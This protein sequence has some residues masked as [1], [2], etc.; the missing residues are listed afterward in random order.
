MGRQALTQ[1]ASGVRF[2]K[3]ASVGALGALFDMSVSTTLIFLFDMLSEFAKLIGA[4]VAIIVMFIVNERWTFANWGQQGWM[5]STKRF[6][7]SN[8]VRS[9]GVGVQFLLVRFLRTLPVS[10]PVAGLDLWII[11][12]LPIAIASSMM[13]NY[14]A[15]SVLTWR[16][17][18]E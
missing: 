8:L 11:I 5:A 15:E 6:I 4:E 3:F 9:V 12:P 10:V 7:R 16:I 1:L 13:L 14:V 2:G 17:L 18:S